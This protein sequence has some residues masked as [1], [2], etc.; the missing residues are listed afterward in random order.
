MHYSIKQLVVGMIKL[1]FAYLMTIVVCLFAVA[2]KTRER[3]G[4]GMFRQ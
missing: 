4:T 2:N 1:L 3:L